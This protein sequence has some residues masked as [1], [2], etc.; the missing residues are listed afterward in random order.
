[1]IKHRTAKLD[2]SWQAHTGCR[3]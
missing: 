3:S 2:K 1:M